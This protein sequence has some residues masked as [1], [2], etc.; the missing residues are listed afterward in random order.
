MSSTDPPVTADLGSAEAQLLERAHALADLHELSL[1]AVEGQGALAIVLGRPG[2]GKSALLGRVCRDAQGLGLRVCRARGSELERD[3]AFGIVR[4]LLERLVRELDPAEQLELF[5]GAAGLAAGVFGLDGGGRAPDGPFAIL[6]GLYW[7][8]AGLLTRGPLLLAVD[9]LHWADDASLQWLAYLR[10]RIESLR[11][12]VVLTSR[13]VDPEHGVLGMLGVDLAVHSLRVGPLAPA[14]TAALIED[15][16]R[17]TPAEAFTHTCQRLTAGNPLAVAELLGELRRMRATP[18]AATAATLDSLAPAG[19]ERSVLDRLG[20]LTEQARKLAHALAVLGEAAPLRLLATLGGLDLDAAASAAEELT[21]AGI[22]DQA[23]ELRF[24]HPLLRAAVYE[25]I[26]VRLRARMHAHAATLLSDERADPQAIAAQLLCSDPAGEAQSVRQ[27]RT[28]ASTAMSQGAPAS[29]ISYLRRALAEPPQQETLGATLTE[30]GVAEMVV[31]DPAASTHLQAALQC[32]S[33]RGERVVLALLLSEVCLYAGE[34]ERV[35]ELLGLALQIAQDC[36]DPELVLLAQRRRIALGLALDLSD[37]KLDEPSLEALQLLAASQRPAAR[38]VRITLALGSAR[39]CEPGER[40]LAL[41]RAGLDGGRFLA[42]ESADAPEA[43]TAAIALVVYDQL[44][45]ALQHTSAMLADAARR[46]SVL[47]FVH[48]AT[49]RALAHLRGGTLAEAEADAQDALRLLQ[50]QSME[51]VAPF[52]RSCLAAALRE[53]GRAREALALLDGGELPAAASGRAAVFETRGRVRIVLGE[54]DGA[55]ADLEAVGEIVQAAG[56][57][58]PSYH[59]WRSPLAFA[60]AGGQP[61]RAA[62]LLASELAD[63]RRTEV[64]SAIGVALAASA[65]LAAP[66]ACDALWQAAIER[67]RHSPARLELARAEVG[68][69]AALRRAGQRVR[70]REPL[71]HGLELAT[72]CGATPLST[73]AAEELRAADGRPRR[74]WLSGVEA[75]TPSE[76]RV[77]RRAA[78]GASNRDIAQALFV[79]T[80][81]VEMHLSNAYRKLGIDSRGLLP[82]ALSD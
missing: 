71:R 29:A 63:A 10:G 62:E 52:P 33:D 45:E 6:H 39:P 35:L 1:S 77:A 2:E 61:E 9:D 13:P 68:Y 19:L 23:E 30:L 57:R 51:F 78:G 50:E 79:T 59:R 66:D 34:R 24:L 12:L 55:I 82:G 46:G 48:G 64:D 81:T 5:D 8:L 43:V 15:A 37:G 32:A 69:G 4:Q 74:P 49:F 3:F 40:P 27:L 38:A 60:L 7:I 73:L 11:V 67:L 18:D 44:D 20:R 14:S 21:Q 72:R 76:L 41:L 42:E 70:A 25:S 22:L 16:L 58:H 75:L 26:G 28:A 53:T 65:A 31:R 56:L 54:L 17:A 47:G 36:G 80:K